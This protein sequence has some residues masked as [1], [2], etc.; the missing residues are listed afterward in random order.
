M[1]FLKY[2]DNLKQE[3]AQAAELTGKETKSLTELK[4][5]ILQK[6]HFLGN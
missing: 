1:L 3:Q 2:L 4:Q 5:S 6:K